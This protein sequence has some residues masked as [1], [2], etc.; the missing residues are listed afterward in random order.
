MYPYIYFNSLLFS[1]GLVDFD[2]LKQISVNE[3][4]RANYLIFP[5]FYE[6]M[7]EYSEEE[8]A[9]N[10]FS[11]ELI[12]Q[13]KKLFYDAIAL[14]RQYQKP[15]VLFYYRDPVKPLPIDYNN[16]IVFRTS[17]FKSTCSNNELAMPA[18]IP[19]IIEQFKEITH[20]EYLN[21]FIL[22]KPNKPAVAFK[23]QSAPLQLSFKTE[24]RLFANK[25]LPK[26]GWNEVPVYYNRGYLARRLALISIINNKKIESDVQITAWNQQKQD[27]ILY[28]KRF[29]ESMYQY[30]YQLCSAGFGNYSFR[31]Y[32]IMASG[33]IP[34][35]VNTDCV[36]PFEHIIP[37]KKQMVWIEEKDAKKTSEI[38]LDFHHSVHP[39]DF[40]DLQMTNR[41]IYETYLT[42]KG[43]LQNL[44]KALAPLQVVK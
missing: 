42:K 26:I 22:P 15:L 31:L 25:L 14:A 11:K 9:M 34:V 36:M 40:K 16:T 41:K 2:F 4:S 32:E 21:N 43:F 37:W 20:K 39:D 17:L 18:F 7:F 8:Y 12:E 19:D 1:T 38:L 29:L 33:R 24:L 30:P 44:D 27:A 13:T 10:G 23:G 3:L 28:K 6:V 35:F 5:V